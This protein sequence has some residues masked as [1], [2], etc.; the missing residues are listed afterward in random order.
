M[1]VSNRLSL[2]ELRTSPWTVPRAHGRVYE[3][4]PGP[5]QELASHHFVDRQLC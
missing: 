2:K 1:R 3:G 4:G 5:G